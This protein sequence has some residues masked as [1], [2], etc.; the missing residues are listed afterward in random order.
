L[1]SSFEEIFKILAH[2]Y[3]LKALYKSP[4]RGDKLY[5]LT[6]NYQFCNQAN[7]QSELFGRTA[8]FKKYPSILFI[9]PWFEYLRIMEYRVE[10]IPGCSFFAT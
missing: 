10:S 9:T 3:I 4:Q 7:S 2:M 6:I 1:A 8:T 5:Q